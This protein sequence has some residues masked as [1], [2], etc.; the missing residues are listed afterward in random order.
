MNKILKIQ[1]MLFD[2]MNKLSD[3]ELMKAFAKREVSRSQALT[4]SAGAYIK[5]I[6]T[7]LKIKEL[8]NN[9]SSKEKALLESL[10]VIENESNN[11]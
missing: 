3:D 10:G 6:N 11:N 2:E 7:Q 4:Q 9:S 1:E 8:V 5:A